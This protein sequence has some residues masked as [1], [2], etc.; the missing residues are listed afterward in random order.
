MQKKLSIGFKALTIIFV[1]QLIL[2]VGVMIFTKIGLSRG[3]AEGNFNT[4]SMF[5]VLGIGSTDIVFLLVYSAF[6]A[7]S[8]GLFL[9]LKWTSTKLVHNLVEQT[10]KRQNRIVNVFSLF[11]PLVLSIVVLSSVFLDFLHDFTVIIGLI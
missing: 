11:I 8:I 6:Y 4:A 1:A 3:L 7:I 10:T 9:F 2:L 5:S